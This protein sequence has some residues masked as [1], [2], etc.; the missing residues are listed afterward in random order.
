MREST[1]TEPTVIY[2]DDFRLDL[3][4]R[5]LQKG[6]QELN[7]PP[8]PFATLEFLIRNRNRV[9]AK[10]ELLEKIWGG[11]REVSTVEHAIGQLRRT[12]GDRYIRTVPGQGYRFIGEVTQ[13]DAQAAAPGQPL[14]PTL[15]EALKST[16]VIPVEE[17]A[18]L[19][20][21]E[22]VKIGKDEHAGNFAARF[23]GRPALEARTPETSAIYEAFSWLQSR[24][25]IA[26]T[27]QAGWY[28][29]T[30]RGQQIGTA[31]NLR[32]FLAQQ[33]GGSGPASSEQIGVDRDTNKRRDEAQVRPQEEARTIDALHEHLA[34][35][36]DRD[37]DRDRERD[38]DES[39]PTL[40][41]AGYVSD[42]TSRTDDLDIATEV[43]T[44]CA[45]MLSTDVEPP[46][47][48]GLFGDWGTGKSFFMER[49]YEEVRSMAAAAGVPVTK[50]RFHS[51]VAQIKFNAWHYIDSNLWA[52]LVSHIIEE[53]AKQVKPE[54]DPA[55]TRKALVSKLETAKEIREEAEQEKKRAEDARVTAESNLSI[56]AKK[57]ADRQVKLDDLR[58]TDFW[59]LVQDDKELKAALESASRDLG[60]PGVMSGIADLQAALTEGHSA[61]GRAKAVLLSLANK[62]ALVALILILLV[63]VPAATWVLNHWLP[64]QPFLALAASITAKLAAGLAVYVAAIQKPLKTVSNALDR[65]DSARKKASEL[66]E[67]KKKEKGAEEIKLEQEVNELRAKEVSA[68]QQLTAAESRIQEVQLKIEELDEGRSL[69]KYLLQ[70]F[71]AEDYRK[72]LGLVST[73]RRDFERLSALLTETETE[74][75]QRIILYI[76]DLDR[77]PPQ[78]VLEVL[79]AVHLLLAFE[80]FV[81]VVGVDPR[82]LLHS[83]EKSY[84]AFQS[85]GDRHGQEWITT[86]QNYLEKIFQIPFSLRPMEPAGF[87][88]LMRSLLPTTLEAPPPDAGGIRG[89]SVV[90][91]AEDMDAPEM[92][93]PA[94]KSTIPQHEPAQ[95]DFDALLIQ[96]WEAEYAQRLFAFV[97]SP[98]AAKRFTNIYRL[99]KAPLSAEGL[100]KFEGTHTGPGDFRAAMVLLAVLTGFPDSAAGVF[101]RVIES[102]GTD[103]TPV[104]MFRD[105]IK[106]GV[107]TK[108]RKRF[109]ECFAPLVSDGLP[110]RLETLAEWLPRVARFTFGAAKVWR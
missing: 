77:C 87:S 70:R 67:V 75:I 55:A 25:L 10:P 30:S 57:R 1:V 90:P 65:L 52:S 63:C 37:R 14:A 92:A 8:K 100:R 69:A 83:L 94:Q 58:A 6:A 68:T 29:V 3:R 66:I 46:L 103:L 17:I 97:P 34:R 24:N 89:P 82:W 76:D 59:K 108:D 18:G 84:S 32:A 44:L 104:S 7:L 86:P 19:V 56:V 38:T 5:S 43:R 20:L 51:R 33:Q 45:V 13:E 64:Q 47:S 110:D 85:W 23:T 109:E 15:A 88:K 107:L 48:I 80:L 61:T 40:R 12:L 91:N 54:E 2:F 16:A 50:S 39:E 74:P 11:A 95:L 60:L 36:E 101:A 31:A 35:D 72:Y 53:L 27:Q 98:R 62:P 41:V 99:L 93:H 28:F 105:A 81:V 78:R 102:Q 49:M 4:L 22:L 21:E 9:I 79:Q 96:P 106:C 71:Q 73:V 42:T 26:P